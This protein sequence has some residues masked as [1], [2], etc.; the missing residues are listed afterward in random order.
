MSIDSSEYISNII[1]NSTS[2]C[3]NTRGFKM[4][5]LN[6]ASLPKHVDELRISD[7]IFPHF[8]LLAFNE[9]RLDSAISNDIVEIHGYNIVR[10]DRSRH[11]G[12]VC[13]YL[14]STINFKIRNDLV[15]D[16]IEAVCLEISKP[17]SQN[18]IVASVYRPPSSA[19][20]F[21][22]ASE[23]MIKMIDDENKEFHI[24]G[25]LYCNMLTNT[26]NQPTKTLNE[27]LETYQLFQLITEPTRVTTNSCTLIDHYITSTPEKIVRSGVIHTGISDHSLIY[28]IRKINPVLN[29]QKKAKKIE[30]RNMKRFNSQLFNEELLTQPWERIVLEKDTNSMWACWKELFMAVLD[31]HAPIQQIRKRAYSYPWITADV[32]QL[33]FDRDKKKRKAIFTK[34]SVDWDAHKTSRNRVNIAIRHAKAEYYRIKIAQQNKI[35]Q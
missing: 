32:K 24:L 21:F 15:P 19:P 27:I 35:S 7:R 22:Q 10:N 2:N 11:G 18:F 34:E 33:I 12:G 25:D 5:F 29:T 31:K 26:T 23:K 17:N 9:P 20:E 13:I 28:G 6:I 16:N 30:V 3:L 1:P 8:D 4:A 14:R